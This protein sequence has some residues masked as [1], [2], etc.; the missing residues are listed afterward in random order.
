[1]VDEEPLCGCATSKSLFIFVRKSLEMHYFYIFMNIFMVH[2]TCSAVF[3]QD[4][5]SLMLNVRFDVTFSP[6]LLILTFFC[7]V[8]RPCLYPSLCFIF[9]ISIKREMQN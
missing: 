3:S 4:A 8:F 1:M 7:V 2:V 6:T 9:N 5:S